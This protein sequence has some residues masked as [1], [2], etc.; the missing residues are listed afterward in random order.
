M[1]GSYKHVTAPDGQL[2][3]RGRTLLDHL[4]DAHEALEE[5]Y[6]AIWWLATRLAEGSEHAP[7]FFVDAAVAEYRTG[8]TMSPGT[9]GKYPADED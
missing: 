1:A 6:G 7:S 8:L 3:P 4:G 9:S 2:L 5:M